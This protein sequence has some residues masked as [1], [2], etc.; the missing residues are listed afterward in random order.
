MIIE[1]QCLLIR[2]ANCLG[3]LVGLAPLKADERKDEATEGAGAVDDERPP[4][5]LSTLCAKRVSCSSECQFAPDPRA[6]DDAR[7]RSSCIGKQFNAA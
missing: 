7:K 5:R 4:R 6:Q 3:G 1:R 2:E